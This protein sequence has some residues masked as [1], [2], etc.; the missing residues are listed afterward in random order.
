MSVWMYFRKGKVMK[1]L[2]AT[3][4][5][6]LAQGFLFL[7][8]A[9]TSSASFY[10]RPPEFGPNKGYHSKP[11]YGPE[12]GY[13]SLPAKNVG[14]PLYGEETG[15]HAPS[16]DISAQGRFHTAPVLAP[17]LSSRE[18]IRTKVDSKRFYR[19]LQ[20][21]VL[22]PDRFYWTKIPNPFNESNGKD[23]TEWLILGDMYSESVR[24]KPE[25]FDLFEMVRLTRFAL[26]QP[27]TGNIIQWSNPNSGRKGTITVSP[28]HWDEAGSL[29]SDLQQ[30]IHFDG[31]TDVAYGTACRGSDGKWK[32]RK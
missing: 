22:Q 13:H 19:V 25:D 21:S 32:I 6:L 3:I 4:A 14:V 5:A 23:P 15:Y 2:T 1:I 7:G 31:M 26:E 12:T 17:R 24:L 30:T 27:L 18:I 11:F 10:G 29:C 9:W 20:R 16:G 28:H 8:L